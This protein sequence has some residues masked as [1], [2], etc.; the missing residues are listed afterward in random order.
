MLIAAAHVIGSLI[1]LVAFGLAT[2]LLGTWER[3]RNQK[4]ALQDASISLGIPIA[5][6]DEAHHRH[7]RWPGKIPHPWPGQNP[8][9]PDR[10]APP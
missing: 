2:I 9:P 10:L 5:Q 7:P 1:A 3:E 4:A 8:P 6:L